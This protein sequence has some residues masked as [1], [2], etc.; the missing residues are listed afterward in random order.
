MPWL[1]VDKT[2][3]LPENYYSSWS[4]EFPSPPHQGD[5]GRAGC[6]PARG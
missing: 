2:R 6:F 1:I 4:V 5:P 3:T